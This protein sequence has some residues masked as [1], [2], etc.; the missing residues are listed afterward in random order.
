MSSTPL[1]RTRRTVTLAVAW[2][3]RLL[4]LTFTVLCTIF[5]WYLTWSAWRLQPAGPGDTDAEFTAGIAMTLGILGGGFSAMAT[6]AHALPAWWLG[7]PLLP[8]AVALVRWWSL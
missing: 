4:V 1:S 5:A 2:V 6:A 3:G 7:V 8:C